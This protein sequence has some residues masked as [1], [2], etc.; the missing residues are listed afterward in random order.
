MFFMIIKNNFQNENKTQKINSKWNKWNLIVSQFNVIPLRII[1]AKFKTGMRLYII[2]EIYP[3]DKR[4]AK[5]KPPTH[6]N[7]PEIK[8]KDYEKKIHKSDHINM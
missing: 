6:K 3:K 1:C 7:N 2:M 8:S 5:K 4:T